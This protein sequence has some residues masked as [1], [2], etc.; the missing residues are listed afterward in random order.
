MTF[1]RRCNGLYIIREVD[2]DGRR[3]LGWKMLSLDAILMNSNWNLQAGG[4]GMLGGQTQT[5]TFPYE[6]FEDL[7]VD[8]LSDDRLHEMSGFSE[9]IRK[10]AAEFMGEVETLF[11]QS[12]GQSG[13]RRR[14]PAIR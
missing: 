9:G 8:T 13:G 5:V 2:E 4:T 12:A 10:K 1:K 11:A 6:I 14:R 3:F 7:T